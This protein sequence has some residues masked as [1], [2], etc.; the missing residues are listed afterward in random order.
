M[1]KQMGQ[2]AVGSATDR[3]F[4]S[5]AVQQ[6]TAVVFS[7]INPCSYIMIAYMGWITMTV[8]QH[9]A[10]SVGLLAT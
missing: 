8:R 9:T 6:C 1:G 3:R 10:A 5:A 2:A 4:L 7:S